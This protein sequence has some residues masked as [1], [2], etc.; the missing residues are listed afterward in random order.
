MALYW[1]V[2]PHGIERLENV[3]HLIDWFDRA[4]TG[5]GYAAAG[6]SPGVVSELCRAGAGFAVSAV[7]GVGD[8]AGV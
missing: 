2:F 8:G 5:L 6:E 1:G 3:E 7:R 4:M